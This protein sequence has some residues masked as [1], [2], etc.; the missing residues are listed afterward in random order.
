MPNPPPKPKLPVPRI[1]PD[2]GPVVHEPGKFYP[3]KKGGGTIY[4]PG[5]PTLPGT[6]RPERVEGPGRPSRRE[7]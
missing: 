6:V 3:L 4:E 7:R 1:I 2:P 5:R